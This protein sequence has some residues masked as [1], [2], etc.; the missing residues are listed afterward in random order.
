MKW[1]GTLEVVSGT[2][3]TEWCPVL[4]ELMGDLRIGVRSPLVTV[5][6]VG[7]LLIFQFMLY[8]PLS[9]N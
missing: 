3:E 6:I 2:L 1:A 7:L 9:W 4:S 8:L 5:V